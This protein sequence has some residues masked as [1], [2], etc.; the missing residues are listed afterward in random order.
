MINGIKKGDNEYFDSGGK[1][2]IMI[3]TAMSV[4]IKTVPTLQQL[5]MM[6][7][8]PQLPKNIERLQETPKK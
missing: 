7:N 6:N 1:V 8:Q 3:N 2:G 4:G 5:W